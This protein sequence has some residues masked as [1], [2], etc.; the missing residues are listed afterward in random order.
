[1]SGCLT[2]LLVEH[3]RA[4][5]IPK[6]TVAGG[7]LRSSCEDRELIAEF[8]AVQEEL[9]ATEHDRA[10]LVEEITKHE[11]WIRNDQEK[12]DLTLHDSERHRY[13]AQ[14][15]ADKETLANLRAKLDPVDRTIKPL[16]RPHGKLGTA[17]TRTMIVL[18]G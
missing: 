5:R 9:N 8:E 12:A 7:E 6:R 13:H 14:V 4:Y 18:W 11:R 17:S 16:P 2:Q 3:C 10:N 15:E 1:M